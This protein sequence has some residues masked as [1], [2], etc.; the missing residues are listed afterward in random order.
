MK[1]VVKNGIIAIK[2]DE[3]SF[4]STILGFTQN[5]DYKHYNEYFSQKNLNLSL[6]YHKQNTPEV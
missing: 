6:K 2:L 4:F 5:W 3:K 1:M